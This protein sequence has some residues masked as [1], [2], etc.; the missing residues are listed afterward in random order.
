ME[1]SDLACRVESDSMN[2]FQC[3]SC[4]KAK[5]PDN[6]CKKKRGYLSFF[7]NDFLWIQRIM[8]KSK[9]SMVM[10]DILRLTIVTFF[11]VVAKK[12]FSLL[13]VDWYLFWVVAG[14]RY[15][16]RV[17]NEN[18]LFITSTGNVS[19]SRWVVTLVSIPLLD[20]VMIHWI[21]I[22]YGFTDNLLCQFWEHQG[23]INEQPWHL[24]NSA[25]YIDLSINPLKEIFTS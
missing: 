4:T 8:S 19:V 15:L 18:A 3:K 21:L 13:P 20:F 24:H 12:N 9:T 23:K 6:N 11:D 16:P 2:S 10:R 5:Y 7:L 14:N 1:A 17:S 25:F 22:E